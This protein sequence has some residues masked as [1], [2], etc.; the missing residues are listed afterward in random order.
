MA[1]EVTDG[2]FR[3]HVTHAYRHFVFAAEPSVGAP[4]I[5]ITRKDTT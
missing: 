4:P 3:V 1:G 5:S 2:K